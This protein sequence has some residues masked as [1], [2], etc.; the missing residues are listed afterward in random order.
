[1]P[2]KRII[3]ILY[4]A[5]ISFAARAQS[6]PVNTK[7]GSVSDAELEMTEYAQDTSAAVLVL[8]RHR[9]VLISLDGQGEFYRK[10]VVYERVKILKESGKSYPEYKLF[11]RE[12]QEI[13]SDIKVVTHNK[14]DGKKTSDKLSKKMIFDETES[15]KIHSVSFAAEN[16]RVGSVVEVSYSFKTP[17]ISEFG[18]ISLQDD[19][20][21]NLCEATVA[22][23]PCFIY[24]IHK[25]GSLS[26][27]NYRE[28]GK[29]RVNTSGGG[30]FE[31]NQVVDHYRAYNVP[32]MKDAPRC[33]CPD[34]YKLAYDYDLRSYDFD[35]EHHQDYSTSWETVDDQIR[36]AG[37]IKEFYNK[38]RIDAAPLKTDDEIQTI[39]RIRNLV[40]QLVKWDGKRDLFPEPAK[41]FKD[42][43]GSASDI[44][45]LVAECLVDIGYKVE[46]VFLRTRGMGEILDHQVKADAY[47]TVV[48]R[49][50]GPSGKVH[51]IDPA[52]RATAVDVM[53]GWCTVK[54]ARVIPKEGNGYWVDLSNLTSN[55]FI[56][57]DT[58]TVS[59][60]GTVFGRTIENGFNSNAGQMKA[61]YARFSSKAGFISEIETD[62]S[63]EIDSLTTSGMDEWTPQASVEYFW[64]AQAVRSGDLLYI[65]PF[66]NK[67]HNESTFRSPERMV[68]VDFPFIETSYYSVTLTVPE[69]WTVES[70]PQTAFFEEKNVKCQALL[71]ALFDGDR[72]IS[73]NF[74]SSNGQLQVPVEEYPEFR[75]YWERLCGIYNVTIVLKKI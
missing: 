54:R 15:G 68:P 73:V 2:L 52:S 67:M 71:K 10:E 35:G 25:R 7:F 14:T 22:Y 42:H 32:A 4:L 5:A 11:Y 49:V 75:K 17:R 60:D 37:I 16:V 39:T 48:L 12:P 33:Y 65:K 21:L 63:I 66:V 69:G 70:L 40:C 29:E 59:A 31:M 55:R 50:T 43:E 51:F 8:Y 26:C 28:I 57:T 44:A 46:P 72:T 6:I 13:L 38:S 1:M 62:C 3:L 74:R 53:V 27:V 30:V 41:A 34:F 45:A 47:S 36:K 61:A 20:P 23:I 19:V 24:N 58:L 56:R 18:T 64:Q 9:D